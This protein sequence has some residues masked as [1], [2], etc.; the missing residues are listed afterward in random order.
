[1]EDFKTD[2]REDK[3]NIVTH[4]KGGLDARLYLANDPKNGDVAN[5]VMIGTPNAGSELADLYHED[6]P[7]KLAV[8]DLLTTVAGY[9]SRK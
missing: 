7:C 6:D 8:Y 4:S 1:M 2:T 5:L 3:I 9:A